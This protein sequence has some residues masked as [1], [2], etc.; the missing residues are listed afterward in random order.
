MKPAALELQSSLLDEINEMDEQLKKQLNRLAELRS[1]K[2]ENPGE[3]DYRITILTPS[4][5]LYTDV[6]SL[7][8]LHCDRLG[9]V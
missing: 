5:I 2:E 9:N 1:K 7:A 4:V 6:C 3:L 8:S